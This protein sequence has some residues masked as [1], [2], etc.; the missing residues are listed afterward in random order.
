MVLD[1]RNRAKLQFGKILNHDI[2]TFCFHG[3]R[4]AGP[5]DTDH[6]S[7]AARPAGCYTGDGIFYDN[8]VLRGR[9]QAPRCFEKG[10]WPRLS[11]QRKPFGFHAVDPHV[12]N[13]FQTGCIEDSRCVLA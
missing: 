3:S 13:P 5:V 2:G 7:E 9:F 6:E 11:C 4:N 1:R 8:R 10:I 12:E